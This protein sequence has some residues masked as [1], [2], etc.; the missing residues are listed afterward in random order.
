MHSY[1]RFIINY[2]HDD[3]DDD[4]KK[5]KKNKL[6]PSQPSRQRVL[7]LWKKRLVGGI[8]ARVDNHRRPAAQDGQ[9]RRR[10]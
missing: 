10:R 5:K 6:Y 7:L 9:Y 2:H 1:I 8:L 4:N 3:V